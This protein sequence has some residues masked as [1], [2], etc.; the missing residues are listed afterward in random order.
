MREFD[1]VVQT[2]KSVWSKHPRFQYSCVV[3]WSGTG[4]LS[5]WSDGEHRMKKWVADKDPYWW[6][7]RNI[8]H[9][10]GYACGAGIVGRSN[11]LTQ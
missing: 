4:D 11:Y 7:Q 10:R 2:C 6:T 9:I 8:N 1:H 3:N 5:K